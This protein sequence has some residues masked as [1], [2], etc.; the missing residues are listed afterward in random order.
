MDS[1]LYLAFILAS[2]GLI[3]SPGPNVLLIVSSALQYGRPAGYYTLAG[4]SLGL[5]ILLLASGVGVAALSTVH[6]QALTWLQAA[7]ALYLAWLGVQSIRTAESLKSAAKQP[8]LAGR[9]FFTR[10]LSVALT[11]P[12]IILF[13]SSFLPQFIDPASPRETQLLVLSITFLA[14]AAFFDG[15]YATAAPWLAPLLMKPKVRTIQ[16]YAVGLL[17]ILIGAI[18]LKQVIGD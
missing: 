12:K 17:F 16:G 6:P 10:G 7:G 15:V 4:T 5:M 13:F 14:L 8:E 11:N 2:S 3:I 9:H 1:N 18:M